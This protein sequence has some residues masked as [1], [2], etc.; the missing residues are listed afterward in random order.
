MIITRDKRCAIVGQT[1]ENFTPVINYLVLLDSNLDTL[2]SRSVGQYGRTSRVIESFDNRLIVVHNASNKTLIYKINTDGVTES[3]FTVDS[4]SNSVGIAQTP[5]SGFVV[6]GWK[7]GG[8]L[9]KI[10]KSGELVWQKSNESMEQISAFDTYSDTSYLIAGRTSGGPEDKIITILTDKDGVVLWE[11]QVGTSG[12]ESVNHLAKNRQGDVV[13]LGWTTNNYYGDPYSSSLLLYKLDADGNQIG[14]KSFIKY[15]MNREAGESFIETSDQGYLIVG[16]NNQWINGRDG[17][18][19]VARTA[20]IIKTDSESQIVSVYNH[21]IS[22]AIQVFP[23]P[24]SDRIRVN[25]SEAMAGRKII[26]LFDYQGRKLK[27]FVV[28]GQNTEISLS[29]M[30]GVIILEVIWQKEVFLKRIL[31]E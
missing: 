27:Q 25:F 24:T 19:V 12:Y 30:K 2:W 7:N 11:N 18:R 21:D 22:N 1:M 23:N 31:K 29:G 28:D 8:S 14:F 16:N 26:N 17:T 6:A 10:D 3:T 9:T 20:E 4:M 5:D 13:G 15:D